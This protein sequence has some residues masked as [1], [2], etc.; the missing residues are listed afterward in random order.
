MKKK[1][2]LVFL[3]TLLMT[4]TACGGGGET[5]KDKESAV[6]IDKSAVF[7]EEE[8][9]FPISDDAISM[10]TIAGDNIYVDQ[11]IFDTSGIQE[12]MHALTSEVAAEETAEPAEDTTK[13]DGE[14]QE[15][16]GD[17]AVE[18]MEEEFI[19]PDVT[20]RITA[21]DGSGKEISKVE[22]SMKGNAN[23]NGVAV[24]EEGNIYTIET[25]YATYEGEDTKDK[26]YLKCYDKSGTELWKSHLNEKMN[27]EEYYIATYV[28]MDAQG[29]LLVDSSRGVEVFDKQGQP[30]KLIEKPEM[31][32]STLRKIRNDEFALVSSDGEKAHIQTVNT[33]SGQLGEKTELPFIYYKYSVHNGRF[34]DLYMSDGYGVYGYNIGEAEPVKL[35]D[36]IS[37]DFGGNNMYQ[38]VFYDENTFYGGYHADMGAKFSKF[39]KVPESEVVDKIN[40]T[41]GCHYLDS[42][43]KQKLIDFNKNN[44]EYKIHIVDYSN[45][46][47]MEDYNQGMT[48]LNTDIVSG[49]VPDILI[50]NERMPVDSYIS[51]GVFADYNE[52]IE[53]DSEFKK[54]DYMTNVL[55]ALSSEDGLYQLAPSFMVS[56]FAGK[57]KNVGSEPGWTM[58]EALKVLA[59]KPKGT[60]L[61]SDMTYS[62]FLYYA[63]WINMEEYVNWETGECHFNSPEFL[64]LLEYAKTL[65]KEIDFS[66]VMDDESYWNEMEV[67]Y[68]EE[69]TLLSMLNL[70]SFRDYQYMKQGNFGEDITL[71]GFPTENGL[72]AGFS[73]NIRFAISALSENREV[74]WEFI[75]YFFSEEYQDDIEYEFPIRL[76]SLDKAEERAWERPYFE[77]ENGNREEYDDTY[78]VNGAEI[79]MTPLTKEETGLVKEY[80]GK[81]TNVA[82]INEDIYNIIVEETESFFNGQKSAAEVAEII[83]SRVKIYV[84][85]NA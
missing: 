61:L 17:E 55:D 45:Y 53:K 36:Y 20:R 15:A 41:L 66:G 62:N 38:L 81:I 75:K 64:S 7:R 80:L 76:S 84:N 49:N 51:K 52:F 25:I 9:V 83:Q 6:T 65:P 74:A 72:G 73:F 16:A 68:R 54:E 10:V 8:T 77:D 34:Y 46:D 19:M 31:M 37:S 4:L 57:T 32:D 1:R 3:L 78:M 2:V 79:K 28:Y 60:Q 30:L 47:T 82:S 85:E 56:T 63:T 21:F 27:E 42:K 43:I 14:S 26:I 67:Q 23:S 11:M 22:I 58:D 70:A 40:L 50:L 29:Q 33:E 5:T 39:T 69:K 13:I 35:M 18:G 48:R 44:P 59:S 24:D 12:R 71:I